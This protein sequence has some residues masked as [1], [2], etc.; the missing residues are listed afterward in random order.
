MQVQ[1]IGPPHGLWGGFLLTRATLSHP[2]IHRSV[3]L[4]SFCGILTAILNLQNIP[5]GLDNF[6]GITLP[7]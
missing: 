6:R 2:L 5:D 3:L 4:D 7:L 1:P